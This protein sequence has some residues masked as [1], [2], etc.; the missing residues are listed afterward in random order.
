M[1]W[2]NKCFGPAVIFFVRLN[3]L[4]PDSVLSSLSGLLPSGSMY[5]SAHITLTRFVASGVTMGACDL[6]SSWPGSLRSHPRSDHETESEY[7]RRC[8]V[9]EARRCGRWQRRPTIELAFSLPVRDLLLARLVE[10]STRGG[11][12]VVALQ[13]SGR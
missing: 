5:N 7:E 12:G 4:I 2:S 13:H 10:V 8:A 6:L 3:S 1:E 11:G 9:V